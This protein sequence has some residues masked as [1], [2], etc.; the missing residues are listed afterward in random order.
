MSWHFS[1]ALGAAYSA[2]TSS[3]GGASAP[4][5]STPTPDPSSLTAKT[6]A[7]CHPSPSGMTSAPST[8]GPG[9][10]LLTWFL[11]GFPVRT[12][13]SLVEAKGSPAKSQGSGHTSRASFAKWNPDTPSWRTP[14]PS[15]FEDLEPSSLIWP[16]WG[17]MRSGACSLRPTAALHTS[18]SGCGLLLPTLTAWDAGRTGASS[19]TDDL[20]VTSTGSVRRRRADGR[21]SNVGLL[22]TL[23][24]C[25]N[26]NRKGA[27][28][29]SGD[30]LATALKRMGGGGPLNPMWCEW[31]QGWPMGWTELGA[32]ETGRFRQWCA[33]HGACCGAASMAAEGDQ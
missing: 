22:P 15:L 33:S 14:Q 7:A 2:A 19:A 4:S 1:R 27:S 10:G 13:P 5:S 31:F 29:A 16:R 20:F 17:S 26:Y 18:G 24:V 12:S 32:S 3:A 28:K 11:A 8:G 21:T 30:G 23:T 9:E 25:G 6:T